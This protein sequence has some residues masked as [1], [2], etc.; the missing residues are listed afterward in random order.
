MRDPLTDAPL[1]PCEVGI[2]DRFRIKTTP[3]E[4]QATI[5]ANAR[6]REKQQHAA[7][8]REE[9]RRAFALQQPQG[10]GLLFPGLRPRNER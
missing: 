10:L 2:V 6:L 3:P 8:T 9:M 4:V 7:R 1:I 5:S